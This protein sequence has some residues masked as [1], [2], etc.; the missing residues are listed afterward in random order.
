MLGSEDGEAADVSTSTS[1]AASVW[2]G[3]HWK[4]QVCSNFRSSPAEP[5]NSGISPSAE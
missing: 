1:T 3:R 2:N 4:T 5:P